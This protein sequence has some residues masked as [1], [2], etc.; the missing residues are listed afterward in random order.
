MAS[1]HDALSTELHCLQ[2]RRKGMD[3]K[4]MPCLLLCPG[5]YKVPGVPANLSDVRQS[6]KRWLASHPKDLLFKCNA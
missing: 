3:E 1:A 2:D 6:Q 5:R 4:A